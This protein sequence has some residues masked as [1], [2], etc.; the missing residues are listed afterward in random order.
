MSC[1]ELALLVALIASPLLGLARLDFGHSACLRDF[2][3]FLWQLSLLNLY[4]NP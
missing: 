4:F 2:W 1:A 3:R